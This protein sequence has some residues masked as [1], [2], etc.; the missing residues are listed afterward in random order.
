MVGK[1]R[2]LTL[3][4]LIHMAAQRRCSAPKNIL[5]DPAD[6]A[7]LNGHRTEPGNP[8]KSAKNRRHIQRHDGA[9]KGDSSR[10]GCSLP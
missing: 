1:N 2:L 3:I 10:C 6:V 8:G 9:L 4:A 5:D 7:A